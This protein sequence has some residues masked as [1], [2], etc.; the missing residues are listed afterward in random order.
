MSAQLRLSLNE[1]SALLKAVFQGCFGHRQD[2]AAITD[3]VMWLETRGFGGLDMVMEA[4]DKDLQL[5]PCKVDINDIEDGVCEID[6]N[7]GS[8]LCVLHMCAD[9]AVDMA[10]KSGK[11]T[12]VIKNA[13]HGRA[14]MASLM[15]ASKFGYAAIAYWQDGHA[16]CSPNAVSP[17]FHAGD[18]EKVELHIETMQ[19]QN[20]PS[21]DASSN[22][23]IA[24]YDHALANGILVK[25]DVY[26]TL[27]Q[28]ADRILVEATDASRQGAGE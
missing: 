24:R 20:P 11:A 9:V 17:S 4:M 2:W 16:Q 15:P 8:L 3:T 19:S 28:I 22:A 23:I 12:L 10:S 26:D 7:N 18:Y 27:N 21:A 5:S 6:L 1:L 25:R 13:R 14:I